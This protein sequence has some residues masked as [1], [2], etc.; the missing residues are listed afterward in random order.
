MR[1]ILASAALALALAAVPAYAAETPVTSTTVEQPA[2]PMHK[3]M[4][5]KH[6]VVKKHHKKTTTAPVAQ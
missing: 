2:K 4:H 6:D 3:K 1:V 5:K